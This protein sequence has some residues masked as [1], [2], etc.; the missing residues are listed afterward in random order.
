MAAT[1]LTGCSKDFPVD[2]V[3][4]A[5]GTL[6]VRAMLGAAV[7]D[8]IE[9]LVPQPLIAE[10]RGRDGRLAKGVVV[11]FE[12]QTS[13]A[14]G[15]LGETAPYVCS[16]T[17]AACSASSVVA[18]DT[19][20]ANGR[21]AARVKLGRTSGASYV[22]IRV[23]ELGVIDSALYTATPGAAVAV[24]AAFRDTLINI[25][26]T[27]TVSALS[28]DRYGNA[29]TEKPV[30]T[31]GPENAFT[32]DATTGRL[33]AQDLGTQFVFAASGAFR[34]STKVRMIPGGTIVGW[35]STDGTLQLINLGRDNIR[36][37][38]SGIVADNGAQPR[39]DATGQRVTALLSV[40]SGA[41][42]SDDAITLTDTNGVQTRYIS[43]AIGF[44]SIMAA[45]Q[46]ADG[47]I[48]VVGRLTQNP[49]TY[50]LYRVATSGAI[51]KVIDVPA[52]ARVY[53][54]A[55]IS[56]DGN[57]IAYLVPVGNNL[58]LRTFAVATG[59]VTTLEPNARSPRWSHGNDR[60]AF[61]V[62]PFGPN[63]HTGAIAIINANGTG[64]LTFGDVQFYPGFAWSPDDAFLIGGNPQTGTY[65]TT[66]LFRI[67]DGYAALFA[68]LNK[69]DVLI[70]YS[71]FDWH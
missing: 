12:A 65:R 10:V 43:P 66:R 16:Q 52:L 34:D 14:P 62:N 31:A 61:T 37:I 55:D 15:H 21:A 17:E 71:Q 30:L 23:P 18:I 46:M 20:D 42:I 4:P 53:A 26:S 2:S 27:I 67:R 32:F 36:T 41:G 56:Y 24:R 68:Y 70:N 49:A 48:L 60:I 6:G 1:L 22:K 64:R 3:T 19:T 69:Y 33:T 13:S 44:Q 25:G 54:G 39:F 47:S 7:T 63:P 51:S 28:T 57:W 38:A 58:E 40:F 5:D 35:N 11:R 45:R 50:S 8:T 59:S 9:A 29:R